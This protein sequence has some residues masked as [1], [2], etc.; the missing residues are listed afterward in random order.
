MPSRTLADMTAWLVSEDGLQAA[1]ADSVV[2]V[3]LVAANE[4]D[5]PAKYHPTKMLVRSDNVRIV[6][7]VQGDRAM[8]V[9]TCPGRDARDA[10]NQLMQLLVELGRKYGNGDGHVY[11][12]AMY[13]NWPSRLPDQLWRVTASIPD[14]EWIR[15]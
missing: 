9:L 15:R 14:P 7:G 1:R 3:T 6:V 13:V 5:D 11:A 2:S 10:R 12:H 4:R 8:C